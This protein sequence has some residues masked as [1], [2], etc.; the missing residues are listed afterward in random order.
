MALGRDPR[1]PFTEDRDAAEASG[2]LDSAASAGMTTR[3]V[4]CPTVTRPSMKR[5][6]V[7]VSFVSTTLGWLCLGSSPPGGRLAVPV[8][9]SARLVEDDA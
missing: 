6:W 9:G 5:S 7:A 1:G 8:D 2:G 4:L 3:R